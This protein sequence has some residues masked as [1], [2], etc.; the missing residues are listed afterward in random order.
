MPQL[1][2]PEGFSWGTATASYQIEGS[3]AEDGKGCSIWDTF[4]HKKGKIQDKQTGDLAC[5][6]YRRYKEDIALMKDL[7]YPNYRFSVA[8]PRIYP[9]GTGAVNTKGLDFYSRLVDELK[10]AGIE[11]FIT[12]YHWDLPQA[13]QDK[14]GW[15]NR[16]TAKY[17]ADYAQT[18]VEKLGDR[19]KNWITL[20][21]PVVSFTL[22]H[23]LGEHAPG[24]TN[25]IKAM[26]VPHH[27]LLAHGWSLQRIK[28]F[29]PSLTVGL[30][31]AFLPVYPKT[32]KDAKAARKAEAFLNRLF[33]DP[34]F[35][36][37]YPEAIKN[38][39]RN[40]GKAFLDEDMKTIST[41][42]DFIGVNC[43]TR[44][45]VKKILNPMP[46]F[47]ESGVGMWGACV[48]HMV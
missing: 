12:L 23:F 20:N 22:G 35:K 18:V 5:D 42:L 8:W 38:M 45:V 34:V 39:I 19:V 7:G 48:R 24:F 47:Q 37:V 2:F 25:P 9:E 13:L 32:P 29:N 15:Y 33:M 27:L 40:D 46:G 1:K 28:A 11:P 41:P 14:G 17:L 30:T 16:D 44:M 6:H 10:S 26:K 31:N 4:S 43:Y 21:E 3:I 36:G